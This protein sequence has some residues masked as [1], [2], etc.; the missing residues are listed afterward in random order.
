MMFYFL[1][2]D[3][4]G[5]LGFYSNLNAHENTEKI[6]S[7]EF[8]CLLVFPSFNEKKSVRICVDERSRLFSLRFFSRLF[9][10]RSTQWI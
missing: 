7:I 1:F 4:A 5:W 8:V 2:V 10:L 3:S 6:Q 9:D